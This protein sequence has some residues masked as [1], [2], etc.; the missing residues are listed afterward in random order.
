MP[1][2]TVR[3]WEQRYGAISPPTSESG[4]RLYSDEDLHRLRLLKS[5]V[6]RGHAIGSIAKMST[7]TLEALLTSAPRS[8]QSQADEDEAD[9][10][11]VVMTGFP[12]QVSSGSVVAQFDS[13]DAVLSDNVDVRATGLIVQVTALYDETVNR[14]VAAA[15]HLGASEVM[16]VF[17]FGTKRAIELAALEGLTLKKA[18]DGALRAE[19]I[20]AEF[21]SV[22]D[23]RSR[24]DAGQ[25]GL[26]LRSQRRFDDA[27]LAR[28]VGLSSTI[29]CEC[30][31]HLSELVLQLSAFERYS[32]ACLSR[33]PADALLH[34]HLGDA[35][36]RAVQMFEAALA[37]V[38]EHEGWDVTGAPSTKRLASK[39]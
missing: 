39:S 9:H 10:V 13:L 17:P 24:R 12:L 11:A 16:V 28:F 8:E 15:E 34:R 37:E 30:P 27:T 7:S 14:I 6:D 19:E 23:D 38:I 5:L 29:A 22:L 35:A 31:R 2:A 33:S 1:A 25:R 4:Q 20:L 21:V 18:P 36:N 32:D 26:W 3:I